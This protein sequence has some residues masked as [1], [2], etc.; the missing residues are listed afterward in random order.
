[1]A[2]ANRTEFVTIVAREISSG[3]DRA[4]RYWM[5]RIEMEAL[6]ASMTSAQRVVAIERV[7]Q[8][9]KQ[10]NKSELQCAAG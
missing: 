8:E 3:I 1:M 10:L 4:L 6:D 2:A 9:Y 5:G 7:L